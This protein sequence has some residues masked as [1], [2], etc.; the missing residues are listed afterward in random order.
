MTKGHAMSLVATWVREQTAG[1]LTE[2]HHLEEGGFTLKGHRESAG[3]FTEVAS[4]VSG[5]NLMDQ[6]A[7]DRVMAQLSPE[8]LD[9]VKRMTD[10]M[11][12]TVADWGNEVTLRQ[13]GVRKFGEK[14]YFPFQVDNQNLSSGIEQGNNDPNST[15]QNQQASVLRPGFGH[16]VLQKAW[17]GVVIDDFNTVCMNHIANMITY[18]TFS[19]SVGSMQALLNQD[20]VLGEGDNAITTKVKALFVQKYGQTK[21]NYL[22]R[23]LQD[24]NGGMRVE[25]DYG[26][27]SQRLLSTAKAAAVVGSGSVAMQQPLSYIRAGY[28][29]NPKYLGQALF[30]GHADGFKNA[31]EE[32][33][34]YSGVAQIKD[35]GKFDIGFSAGNADWLNGHDSDLTKWMKFR[36]GALRLMGKEGFK[37]FRDQLN[38]IG[39]FL[40]G[41]MDAITWGRMWEAVK[42]EQA[43]AH[44]GMDVHSEEFLRDIVA[45][46]F[47][48]VMMATQV[49][50]TTM[51]RSQLM[52]DKHVAAQT[53]GAFKAEPT[54]TACMLIDAAKQ[55]PK[56][57]ATATVLFLMSA[58]AQAAVKGLWGAGRKDDDDKT[59]WEKFL[60]SFF[61]N[62]SDE[63]NPVKLIPGAADIWDAVANFR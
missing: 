33:K 57:A 23:Y 50:D 19:E 4:N 45:P 2:T 43:K 27:I 42:L 41:K 53:L 21:Y 30:T 15:G 37:G 55:G 54:L 20:V 28:M 1:I 36:D 61:G 22:T 59:F 51:T 6:A 7:M 40:P 46:R 26:K 16:R 12:S 13:L 35:T 52:R 31:F 44:P 10:Y 39:G 38:S 47:N 56:R 63:V 11:S 29:I 60:S 14:H 34:A 8:M 18:S 58:V 32:A 25:D 5:Q 48:D 3:R 49:Y 62:L 17:R 9:Y 24:M